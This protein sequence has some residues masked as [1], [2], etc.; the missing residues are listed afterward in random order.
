MKINVI[1]RQFNQEERIATEISMIA[2]LRTRNFIEFFR[3]E[4]FLLTIFILVL[5]NEIVRKLIALF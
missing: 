2:K 5:G 3:N 4:I 1:G